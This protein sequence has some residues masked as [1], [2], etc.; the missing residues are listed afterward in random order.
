MLTKKRYK[1]NVTCTNLYGGKFFQS[2]DISAKH[3]PLCSVFDLQKKDDY[4]SHSLAT[5]NFK[6]L[7][8]FDQYLAKN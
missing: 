2:F 3:L 6:L 1:S 4:Y 7:F 8:L 5:L